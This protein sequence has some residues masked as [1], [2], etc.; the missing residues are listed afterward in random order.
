MA[1]PAE[2]PVKVT[3]QLP[4][5]DR[6]QGAPTVPTAVADETKVTVPLG[7]L[8]GTVASVTVAVHVEVPGRVN[9][10]GVQRTVVTV[11]SAFEKKATSARLSGVG[12]VVPPL[13]MVMHV[14]A[15][16]VPLHMAVPVAVG[17]PVT[18]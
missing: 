8:V 1:V 7:I 10:L 16:L 13:V 12:P 18:T 15:K 11:L 3:E 9:E 2:T 14:L 4:V 6:V 5:R 17:V